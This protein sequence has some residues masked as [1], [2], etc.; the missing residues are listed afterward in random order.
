MT[1]LFLLT[2]VVWF[3]NIKYVR[4]VTKDTKEKYIV[5]GCVDIKRNPEKRQRDT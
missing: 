1:T 5:K 3:M 2:N 4:E